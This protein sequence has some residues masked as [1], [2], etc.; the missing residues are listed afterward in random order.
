MLI[1]ALRLENYINHVHDFLP[2]WTTSG[3]RKVARF[4]M[5]AG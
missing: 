5:T 1:E 3:H 4:F 2:C